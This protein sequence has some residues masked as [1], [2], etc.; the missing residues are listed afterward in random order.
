MDRSYFFVAGAAGLAA[1]A[2][3]EAEAA[4]CAGTPDWAL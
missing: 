4:G 3:V 1:D 2:G